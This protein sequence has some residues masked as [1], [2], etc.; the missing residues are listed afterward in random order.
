ML[1]AVGAAEH[2]KLLPVPLEVPPRPDRHPAIQ[3][4]ASP[5]NRSFQLFRKR[6]SILAAILVA[7]RPDHHREVRG[8]RFEASAVRSHLAVTA[9]A[10]KDGRP[11]NHPGPPRYAIL[12][13]L[14][15]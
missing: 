9:R 3:V 13:R 7:A 14:G 4:M 1:R 12:V 8:P 10:S 5:C 11:P 2:A 6:T 15:R